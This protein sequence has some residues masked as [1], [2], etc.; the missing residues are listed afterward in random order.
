MDVLSG[1]RHT[2]GNTW[3]N[4]DYTL[5]VD[6]Q[7]L[8]LWLSGFLNV[9]AETGFGTNMFRD[10]GAIVPVNT[11]FP[12]SND[13]TTALINATFMQFLSEKFGL[14]IGK[15]NTLTLSE[16]EFYGN[17]S[18]QFLNAASVF[19]MTLEQ[20]PLSAYGWLSVT[21]DLQIIDPGLK[22][23]LVTG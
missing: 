14:V 19:P 10:T 6:T 21:A 20:A 13:H 22:K 4:V 23:S 3:G 5:N 16:Q 12:A 18:T 2:G 9:S 17:Y 1:G 11:A 15:F 8:G 7:K